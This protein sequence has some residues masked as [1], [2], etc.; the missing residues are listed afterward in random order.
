MTDAAVLADPSL[1][2]ALWADALA[3][4]ALFAIDPVGTGGIL[5]RAAAG[6]VRDQWLA[7]LRDMLPADARLRRMPARIED[8]RLLGGLDL[9][10]TLR[11]GRPVAERGLLADADIVLVA[12]AER[13]PPS[14]AA[15]LGAVLDNGEVA[16]ERDGL[17]LRLPA[18]PGIVAFD[19]GAAEDERAPAA[20]AD[21][22][23][24]HL[25]LDA[26]GRAAATPDG[27][28][29]A[30]VA[31]AR[32]LLPR[33]TAE[34]GILDALCGT[35]LALGVFSLRAP[36]LALRAAHAAAALAGR[37]DVATED[38]ELAA[39]LVLAPRATRLPAQEQAEDAAEPEPE[40][41]QQDAGGAQPDADD[42]DAAAD[43]TLDD[44]VLAAAAASIPAGLLALLAQGRAPRTAAAGRAGL[45]VKAAR[46]GRPFGVRQGEPRGGNR[47]NV[48]ETLRAAAPWQTLRRRA[49]D[50]AAPAPRIAI[51]REDFRIVRFRHR[52]ET[53]TIFVVD[54]S[55]SAA[56]QRLAEAKGAVELLL[57]EC[58]VRRDK[59]ALLAFRGQG[60]EL[61][62]PP[63]SSLVRA[64]RNLAGLPGGGGTPIAAAIDAACLLAD[65]VRR[66]GQ[67]P[68]IV[69]LTDGRANIARDGTPGRARAQQEALAAARQLAA[70]GFA[71]LLLDT[72]PRP[73][74]QA[75]QLAAAMA[76]RY[77][78]LPY[79]DAGA[80]SAA[81]MDGTR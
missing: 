17:T 38:A 15:R 23:A 35:A 51:R 77:R 37:T 7:L 31:T 12:M 64:K 74:P 53:T 66:R 79:A 6:P 58:Y 5:V 61:L 29:R 65:A 59:V 9:A 42:S 50:S 34:P 4:A 56:L 14:T 18:R 68:S 78:P 81:V 45:P 1:A 26:I 25:A 44:M 19:E 69:F 36:L 21:R 43:R 49:G 22:Q 28:S 70:S 71:A 33:V 46:R 67:T 72:S 11:A 80:L 20:L 8:G 41:E 63:T 54:A 27:P 30:D 3:A 57:A 75:E 76:A 48:I 16:V 62:L 40:P 55:G 52:S 60:A 10:A 2:D 39:R 47:L 24:F 32:S 13:L 73:A